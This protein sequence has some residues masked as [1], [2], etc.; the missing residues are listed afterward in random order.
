MAAEMPLSLELLTYYQARVAASEEEM[1]A[2]RDRIDE[3][4]VKREEVHTAR[5]ELQKRNAEVADLQRALSDS[6]VYVWEERERCQRLQAEND[7][8]RIQETE[9]RRKIQHLLVLV[10]PL[11]QDVTFVRTQP[12]ASCGGM[13]TTQVGAG[14]GGVQMRRPRQPAGPSAA[15]GAPPMA[16]GMTSGRVTADAEGTTRLLRTVY[17]PNENV[18]TL[19][20]TIESLRAQLEEQERLSRERIAALLEDRR[21]RI[22]EEGARRATDAEH[23]RATAATLHRTEA[24]L[25]KHAS[26]YLS[27]R[28]ESLTRQ[29]ADAERVEEL[30]SELQ[31]RREEVVALR[32]DAMAEVQ[33]PSKG[34]AL[35]WYCALT[36]YSSPARPFAALDR[37]ATRYWAAREP[38]PRVPTAVQF[39]EI[40]AQRA[41]A[42]KVPSSGTVPS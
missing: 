18:D 13:R 42:K 1:A 6:H 36:W 5:W 28:H 20:L 12:P 4:D 9:D 35:T 11:T 30:R 23:A 24:L 8:L 17:M 34:F 7:E 3:V 29:R 2:L 37:P 31:G 14:T 39:L 25:Q 21:L 26:D 10:E 15:A 22:A 40:R 32:A 38:L 27:I 41:H 16:A 33:H 19:L